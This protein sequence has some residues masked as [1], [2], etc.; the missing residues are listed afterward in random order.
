MEQHIVTE[1]PFAGGLLGKKSIMEQLKPS[2][3]LLLYDRSHRRL[4]VYIGP[5]KT[6]ST[7]LQTF[8]AKYANRDSAIAATAMEAWNYLLLQSL[9]R[10]LHKKTEKPAILKEVR[11]EFQGQS[12]ALN[13][14]VASEFL[15]TN[16]DQFKHFSEWSN[17]TTPEIVIH[18]RTPRFSHLKSLWK[19]H[20]QKGKGRPWYGWPFRRFVCSKKTNHFLPDMLS[21]TFDPIGTARNI[22]HKL[23]LPVY[24][25]DMAG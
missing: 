7:T 20:S 24:M 15:Y 9:L 21:T 22:L 6:G 16:P 17:V 13:L 11:K 14:V 12:S 5:A 3:N 25:M 8:L 2:G 1:V 18:S 23:K 19:Q 10:N 4:V